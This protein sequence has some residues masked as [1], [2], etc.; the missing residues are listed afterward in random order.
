MK[1]HAAKPPTITSDRSTQRSHRQALE[2][3]AGDPEVILRLRDGRV[4]S[5]DRLLSV[6]YINSPR[7]GVLSVPYVT[8]DRFDAVDISQSA[9]EIGR[10]SP[11]AAE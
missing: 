8:K 11:V 3:R 2:L 7:Q 6:D 10:Q 4:E 1:K 9:S 5:F